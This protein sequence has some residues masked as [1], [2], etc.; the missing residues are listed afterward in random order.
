MKSYIDL[1]ESLNILDSNVKNNKIEKVGI[2][3]G[4]K[5]IIA[6]DVLSKINNPPFNKSAMD[7]YAINK[8][9]NKECKNEF[10][11]IGE[12]FAGET[13]DKELD[14]NQCI[15]IMTGA[16]IPKG[17]NAVVKKEDV[18]IED[19]K[20]KCIKPININEN[21]CFI[22]E[23]IKENQILIK[24][25][26]KLD[27]ADIGIL[28]SSGINEVFVYTKP[29]IGFLSTGD[30]VIDIDENLQEG[31]IYNSNKYSIISRIMELGY[32]VNYVEHIK[33]DYKFIGQKIKELSKD[34]DLIITT[35]GASVGDKDL[36]KDAITYINGEKLFW[37]INIKPGS[38]VLASKYNDTTIISLS[39]NPTAALT[40]FELLV[41]P[42]IEKLNG[43]EHIVIHKEKAILVDDFNKKSKNKR[44]VRGK[45]FFEDGKQYV[46][47][48]QVKSGNGILSSSLNS[49]CLIEIKKDSNGLNK[50]EIID[51]IKL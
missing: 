22:G 50:G 41:K 35:G 11:I 24:K 34:V 45:C 18:G 20:I 13:F 26:K 42:T 31:K 7:G 17:A 12:V 3:Q 4:L 27:Y 2:L 9:F 32:E 43:K 15:K 5:R 37:K 6:Q 21:I 30:E 39:G 23:D 47:I 8:D 44:F 14:K 33:D 40:T 48:T 19:N 51:I 49:N 29:Q 36:L 1:E 10:E 38:A 28:A 16:P 46:R 25:G